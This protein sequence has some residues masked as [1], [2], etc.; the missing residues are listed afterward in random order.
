M[1]IDDKFTWKDWWFSVGIAVVGVTVI[2][3][4]MLGVVALGVAFR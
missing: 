3:L 2:S 1:N 4:M